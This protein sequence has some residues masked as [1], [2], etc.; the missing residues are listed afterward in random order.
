MILV[1]GRIECMRLIHL[2]RGASGLFAECRTTAEGRT[3]CLRACTRCVRACVLAAS[4]AQGQL[5]RAQATRRI[6]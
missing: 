4:C 2:L 5:K 6:A 3:C 1:K